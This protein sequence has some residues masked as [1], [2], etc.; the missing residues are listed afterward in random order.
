MLLSKKI[1]QTLAIA[2]GISFNLKNIVLF[3]VQ[4]IPFDI[5]SVHKSH[6][7]SHLNPTER[8]ARMEAQRNEENSDGGTGLGHDTET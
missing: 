7:S 3:I 4:N 5:S 2:A 1:Y 6:C 8:I